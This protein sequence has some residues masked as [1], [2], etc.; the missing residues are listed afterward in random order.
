MFLWDI[1]LVNIPLCVSNP[2]NTH[3]GVPPTQDACLDVPPS[4]DPSLDAYVG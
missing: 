1:G 2:P 4:L 3:V